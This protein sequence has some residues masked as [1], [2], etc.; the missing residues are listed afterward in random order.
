MSVYL[1]DA[2]VGVSHIVKQPTST[3]LT[4]IALRPDAE[5]IQRYEADE[6]VKAD[7][8]VEI[9]A[10]STSTK[11]LVNVK[12][13]SP[14]V[15][16]D[17]NNYSYLIAER[18]LTIPEY[19]VETLEKGREEYQF[20][21]YIYEIGDIEP[22]SMHSLIGNKTITTRNITCL[23]KSLV[24]F[25]YWSSATAIAVYTTTTTLYGAAQAV[26]G[27]AIS[28]N[29][30]TIKAPNITL[31]GHTTYFTST[32]YNALTDIRRQY[33]IEVYRA[34]KNNL[35][36]DGWDCSQQLNHIVSCVNTT[37]HKLT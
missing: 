32:F 24:R 36:I 11:T 13:L 29:T 10:Y 34:P 12:I 14:T 1:G 8:G 6:Y 5:I 2:K 18:F 26:A 27:P 21:S 33:V 15:T 4:P 25:I 17:T 23:P 19:S 28:N 31:R 30:L 16:V 37:N 3:E 20:S 9:P 35:N 7:L 22:N